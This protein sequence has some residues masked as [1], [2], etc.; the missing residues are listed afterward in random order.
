MCTIFLRF[1]EVEPFGG[2]PCLTPLG[3]FITTITLSFVLLLNNL[4][5]NLKE[6]VTIWSCEQLPSNFVPSK[7]L[8]ID[9]MKLISQ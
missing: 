2:F 4:V 3:F 7:F 1:V 9:V 6:I 5:N 8:K